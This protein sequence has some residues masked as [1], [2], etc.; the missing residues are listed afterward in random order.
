MASQA[1]QP[2]HTNPAV[3]RPGAGLGNVTFQRKSFSIFPPG[4]EKAERQANSQGRV[5]GD[6]PACRPP[7]RGSLPPS[8]GPLQRPRSDSHRLTEFIL[9]K[10]KWISQLIGEEG[11]CHR[12]ITVRPGVCPSPPALIQ[13]PP[14][15]C[16]LGPPEKSH[17]RPPLR[18]TGAGTSALAP[19]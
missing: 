17:P 7:T 5:W 18:S 6:R 16:L 12:L 1:W 19:P 14:G 11:A 13:L 15:P 3:S 9:A 10:D 2:L 4:K 8:A